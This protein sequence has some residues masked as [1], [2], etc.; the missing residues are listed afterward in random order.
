M[1]LRELLGI[2][3]PLIQ[4]P[5]AVSQGS[6]LAVAVSNA[7]ALGSLPCA[8]LTVEAMRAE[9]E[10]MKAQTSRPVNVNFFVHTPPAADAAREA[11]WREALAPYYKEFAIDAAALPAGPG[12]PPF[13]S[14]AAEVVAEFKP[15]LGS[16]RFGLPSAEL[17]PRGKAWRPHGI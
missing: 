9:L 13:S 3:V 8:M 10:T 16:F 17:L 6:A 7:G 1:T 2:E 15:A 11:R 12:R 4:A 14:E 5:M